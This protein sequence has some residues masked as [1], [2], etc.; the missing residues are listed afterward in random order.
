M[1]SHNHQDQELLFNDQDK[2]HDVSG[3]KHDQDLTVKDNDFPHCITAAGSKIV[4]TIVKQHFHFNT[5]SVLVNQNVTQNYTRD[6]RYSRFSDT[7]SE[8]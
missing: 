8:Y 2:F 5:N 6:G 1:S 7:H 3:V 4:D